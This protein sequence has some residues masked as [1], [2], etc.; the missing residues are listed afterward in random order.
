MADV[1]FSCS[2]GK[3]KGV[4]HEASPAT[5]CHLTCYC[6]D[7]R[8]FARHMGQLDKLL[9][10]GGS[11]IVQILPAR[12]EIIEGAEQIACLRL[13][14]KGLHRWYAR[15]CNT[16]LANTPGSSKIPFAGMWRPLFESHA[17]FGPV[18]SLGFTKMA[19]PGGPRRDKGLMRM[20][21]SLIARSV[22]A[23]LNGTAR[24]S[25]FFDDTGAPVAVPE[26][27]SK[28]ARAAAYRE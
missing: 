16:P 9:P 5:A 19:L 2:C 15:C 18:V 1:A 28:E 24:Q 14:P 10:G 13:S 23:Y 25:P 17:E 26:V 20:L 4:L 22:A 7:C 11:P 21:G 27:I 6:K 3:L 12:V 8:A